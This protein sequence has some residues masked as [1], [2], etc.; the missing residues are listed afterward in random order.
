LVSKGLK[1]KCRISYWRIPPR[2]QRRLQCSGARQHEEDRQHVDRSDR[3]P[4][5]CPKVKKKVKP[6]FEELLAKYKNKGV[7]QK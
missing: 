7:S 1:R 6:T 5:R 4:Q 2:L 3:C